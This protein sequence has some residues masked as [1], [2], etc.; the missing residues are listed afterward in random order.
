MEPKRTASKMMGSAANAEDGPLKRTSNLDSIKYMLKENADKVTFSNAETEEFEILIR[1]NDLD[2]ARHKHWIKIWGKNISNS[3]KSIQE[4]EKT[5]KGYKEDIEKKRQEIVELKQE[6]EV[7]LA[8]EKQGE[9]REEEL[10]RFVKE[11]MT[12]F[13]E[14]KLE[15]EGLSLEEEGE[16]AQDEK[17]A[18]DGEKKMIKKK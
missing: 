6:E 4:L 13:L 9:A 15:K 12:K 3:Q 5:I 16:E 17:V 2:I 1:H 18:A 11:E 7:I 10:Q 14:G 8:I